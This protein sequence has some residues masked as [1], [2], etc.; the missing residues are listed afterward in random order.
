METRRVAWSVLASY[1]G[2]EGRL[3]EGVAPTGTVSGDAVP[4]CTDE[5]LRISN[6]T[7]GAM[8]EGQA[9]LPRRLRAPED[10]VKRDTAVPRCGA[11]A[12]PL[13]AGGCGRLS[14]QVSC[15][16]AALPRCPSRETMP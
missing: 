8:R 12:T 2:E 3:R 10:T 13:G 4:G 15:G 6:A 1:W 9:G 14:A 11:L 7:E 16:A 5:R